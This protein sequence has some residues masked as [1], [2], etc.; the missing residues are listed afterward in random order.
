[1]LMHLFS[2]YII[3]DMKFTSRSFTEQ[4]IQE[5]AIK[6]FEKE[7]GTNEYINFTHGV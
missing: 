3:N 6:D 5:I 7:K 2:F 1:M 4:R